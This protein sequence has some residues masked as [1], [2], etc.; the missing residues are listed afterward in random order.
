MALKDTSDVVDLVRKQMAKEITGDKKIPKGTRL[1]YCC[2]GHA[3]DQNLHFNILLH[4]PIAELSDIYDVEEI[5]RCIHI[6]LDRA[7]FKAV[8]SVN[9]SVS[10]EHGVGQ[11]KRA[12]MNIARS[13]TELTLMAALK[14]TLDPNGI[15]NPGKVIPDGY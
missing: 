5:K 11:Q 8:L 15:L 3:G 14:R 12:I 2:F 6:S 10:A 13:Q 1:E 9:G 4:L 7:V